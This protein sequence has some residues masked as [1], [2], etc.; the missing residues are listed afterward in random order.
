M[1]SGALPE[2]TVCEHS[3]P[4]N[5]Q[6]QVKMVSC[7]KK[8]YVKMI[9]KLCYLIW[10]KAPLKWSEAK[11]KYV[12]CSDDSKLEILFAIHGRHVLQIKEDCNHSACCQRTVPKPASLIQWGC[13]SA[14]SMDSLHKWKGTINAEEYIEALEQH[15]PIQTLSRRA[16]DISTTQC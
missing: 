2:I 11:W 3:L 9:Q 10:A 16:L 15:P 12:L 1:G 6:M 7:K 5:P 8:P 13:I 14:Y 4:C